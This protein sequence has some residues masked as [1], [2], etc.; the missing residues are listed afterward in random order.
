MTWKGL[1]KKY[2]N[3]L[4]YGRNLPLLE[5]TPIKNN[6]IHHGSTFFLN[7]GLV[8]RYTGYNIAATPLN[9]AQPWRLFLCLN[10]GSLD[11]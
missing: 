1:M 8:C 6:R 3:I 10:S 7:Y 11:G 2:V 5:I 4:K 9:N